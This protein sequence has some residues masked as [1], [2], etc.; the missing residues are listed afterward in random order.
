[1][2]F[3]RILRPWHQPERLITPEA[4]FLNRRR[5]LKTLSWAGVG[6][7]LTPMISHT[8]GLAS[9]DPLAETLPLSANQNSA[10]K[11]AGRPL[12]QRVVAAT[13]NNFYE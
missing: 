9:P 6:A 10:F 11:D 1:M 8:A 7:M 2:V 3:I 13:Y 5:L 12:T 4:V